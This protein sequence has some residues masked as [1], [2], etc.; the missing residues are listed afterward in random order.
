[1]ANSNKS[2]SEPKDGRSYIWATCVYPESAPEGWKEK[3]A[4]LYLAGFISPLHD[5]DH[6]ETGEI[7]KAHY[8]VA[9]KFPS[10]KSR[11]QIKELTDQIGGVGQERLSNFRS[12]ARYLCHLDQPHKFQYDIKDVESFGG[13]DYQSEI[14]AP[15][16]K[17]LIVADMLDWLEENRDIHKYS[18]NKFLIYCRNNQE[19][20][21]RA[22]CDNCSYIIREN[23]ESMKWTDQE[24]AAQE[25]IEQE[26]V[27][28]KDISGTIPLH[29]RRKLRKL[30]DKGIVQDQDQEDQ[31]M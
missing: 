30:S 14:S 11:E 31:I 1:M 26:R 20:W 28:K 3:L 7:K 23:L 5:K 4:D 22:L 9:L 8:H 12:Y 29:E 16:D 2:N 19:S 10:K 18:F 25:R 24:D 15:S 17:Y 27:Q 13:M 6:E 21:F